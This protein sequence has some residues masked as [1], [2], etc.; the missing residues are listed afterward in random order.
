MSLCVI[1]GKACRCQPDD[2]Q[3]CELACQ[4]LAELTCGIKGCV[5][6]RYHSNLPE[7]HPHRWCSTTW[8][9]VL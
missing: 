4:R 1:D 2:G 3:F 9:S 5:L 7:T 6:P 8:I